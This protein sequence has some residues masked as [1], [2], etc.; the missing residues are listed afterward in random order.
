MAGYKVRLELTVILV[1]S[2]DLT[3]DTSDFTSRSI[4]CDCLAATS[5]IRQSERPYPYM[6]P[7][8]LRANP[9]VE[10][11][12]WEF[13]V[14]LPPASRSQTGI[15]I[16]FSPEKITLD[17]VLFPQNR[18]LQSDDSSKFVLVSFEKL[19]FPDASPRVA[20]NY[21]VRFFQKGLFLNG[22]QYRFYGHSNSQL[23]RLGNQSA[24]MF[25]AL[26]YVALAQLFPPR[27]NHLLR[28]TWS[29]TVGSRP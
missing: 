29:C 22:V 15:H 25:S 4:S 2:F 19:R 5:T 28:G 20:E 16:S 27:G 8:I 26:S 11:D 9:T 1:G 14:N 18:I 23:V 7:V 6:A 24:Y 3:I 21:M 17:R 13:Q 12:S 10:D